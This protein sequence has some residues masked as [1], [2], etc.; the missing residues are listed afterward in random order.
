MKK[1]CLLVVAICV[2]TLLLLSGHTADAV[3]GGCPRPYVIRRGDTLYS[4]ARR[5]GTTVG[6]LVR[7]NSIRNPN[8]IY[9]GQVLCL[10]APQAPVAQDTGLV[11]IEVMF[12]DVITPGLSLDPLVR[13]EFPLA[14]GEEGFSFAQ[15]SP[16]LRGEIDDDA[17]VLFWVSRPQGAP[18]Y[19]LVSV[20]EDEP[21]GVLRPEEE[22]AEPIEPLIPSGE[23]ATL[24]DL[25]A[26]SQPVA[27][28]NV[29]S[30]IIWL[31]APSGE[32]YPLPVAALGHAET[33]ADAK[34]D[35]RDVYLALMR[36]GTDN[37]RAALVLGGEEVYGPQGLTGTERRRWWSGRSNQIYRW[38]R[39][40]PHVV[41]W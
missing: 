31:E 23:T 2:T 29:A 34:A 33:P 38:L 25:E 12:T 6:T 35:Y 27:G 4:I 1:R 13:A 32:R 21:L 5:Y 36:Q 15:D 10:P 8:L 16:E 22:R 7:L 28:K 24:T 40:W 9:V 37:Y 41:R 18:A 30:I 3:A 20:G 26:P 14:P 19:V 11:V 17:P 39:S